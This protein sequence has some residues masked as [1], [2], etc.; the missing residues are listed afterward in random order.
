MAAKKQASRAAKSAG[1][2]KKSKTP[3]GNKRVA[4]TR[5]GVASTLVPKAARLQAELCDTIERDIAGRI[6]TH[7]REVVRLRAQMAARPEAKPPLMILSHGDSWFNYPLN[8]NKVE[9]PIRDT[10]IIAHLRKM[11]S[12]AP[13]ILNLSHFGDATTDEMGLEKQ[14]RLIKA[15]TTPENWLNGKPDAILFSGGGN[16]IA[17]DPFCIYLN[18]KNSGLPG[19]DTTRFAGRLASVEASYL[20]LFAFRDH[21]AAGVPIFGHPYDLARPIPSPHPPCTGPWMWPGLSFTGW[22]IV[23]GT[24]IIHDALIAFRDMLLRL[25]ASPRP[26]F[27]FTEVPTQGTLTNADWANEL[28]PY[29]PGFEKLAQVFLSALQ[30]HFPGRI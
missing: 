6:H 11:G 10:D 20:D 13:K 16:D 9:V 12:P 22:N 29:P 18:Y 19:L 28:H 24:E 2:K 17:G 5:A 27:N 14:K 21:F 8:G 1:R 4:K 7:Q 3:K 30:S 15:L 23:E 25:E 26:N